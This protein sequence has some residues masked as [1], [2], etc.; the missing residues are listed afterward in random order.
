MNSPMIEAG[1][2]RSTRT[3]SLTDR[4]L[5]LAVGDETTLT[6][7]IDPGEHDASEDGLSA[8]KTLLST[9]ASKAITRAKQRVAGLEYQTESAAFVTSRNRIYVAVIVTRIS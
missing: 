1:A 8:A 3:G 4:L 5:A 6:A 2:T 7:Y 9:T